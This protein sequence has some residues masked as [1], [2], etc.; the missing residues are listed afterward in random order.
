MRVTLP[1]SAIALALSASFASAT[2]DVADERATEIGDVPATGGIH[3]FVLFGAGL[4]DIESNTIAG[5]GRV[6]MGDERSTSVF[7]DANSDSVGHPA[8]TGEIAYTFGESR[9]EVFVGSSL[10]NLL[11]FDVSQALG[12]RTQ[13]ESAGIF[14]IAGLFSGMPGKV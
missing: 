9:T 13:L 10:E 7:D 12:V 11:T 8:L 5:G 3:G 6:E 14:S 2:D 1:L 4:M